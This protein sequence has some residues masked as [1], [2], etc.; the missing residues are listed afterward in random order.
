MMR[1]AKGTQT[2]FEAPTWSEV[3]TM[4]LS[5]AK[6]IHQTHFKPDVILA[7]SRGGWIPARIHSDLMENSNLA[8]VRTECYVGINEVK[9]TP[10]LTQQ[11]SERIDGKGVL[12]V[13]DIAD[14]GRSLKLVK[15]HVIQKGATEVRVATLFCKPWSTLKPDYWERETEFWV[16]FPWDLKETVRKTFEKRRALSVSQLSEQLVNA[17]LPKGLVGGFLGEIAE[18]KSC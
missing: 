12:I 9:P 18:E 8:T 10:T 4:L 5:Q 1:E 6:E 15:E 14:T 11:L 16:A 7:V 17:G 13:D 3:Y 2:R